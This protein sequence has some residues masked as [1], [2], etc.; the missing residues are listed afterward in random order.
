MGTSAQWSGAAVGP[1]QRRKS[2][3][4]QNTN[5]NVNLPSRALLDCHSG[6]LDSQIDQ[7]GSAHPSEAADSIRTVVSNIAP[8]REWNFEMP[9]ATSPFA[10]LWVS[11]RAI[12]LG[13]C[14]QAQ[15]NF[16]ACIPQIFLIQC[17][18]FFANSSTATGLRERKQ[19]DM[20]RYQQN[21]CAN[22]IRLLL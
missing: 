2:L 18:L 1:L 8:D 22:S 20:H 4:P 7:S 12:Q 10:E 19:L 15:T 14:S 21:I 9:L 6:R 16:L 11:A 13:P 17:I 3:A 5:F